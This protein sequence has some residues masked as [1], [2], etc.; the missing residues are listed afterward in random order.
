MKECFAHIFHIN[1]V[2]YNSVMYQ[3]LM[4]M[5]QG[6]GDNSL[7]QWEETQQRSAGAA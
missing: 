1:I 2:K 4:L 5:F 6:H 3:L 7:A